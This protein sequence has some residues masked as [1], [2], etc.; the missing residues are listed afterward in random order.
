MT[1]IDLLL[2]KLYRKKLFEFSFGMI[3][4]LL[5]L[6][7]LLIA[8]NYNI[9]LFSIG[10]LFVYYLT[11]IEIV[12]L[13]IHETGIKFIYPTR[14]RKRDFFY[15]YQE[16]KKVVYHGYGGKYSGNFINFHLKRNTE[17][18]EKS[19]KIYASKND[20]IEIMKYIN[21]KHNIES[22]FL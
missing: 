13:E 6:F 1:E 4:I 20:Y 17:N 18:K 15:K 8:T 19:I 21:T 7:T 5:L 9:L 3:V 2:K 10:F 14:L 22:Y 12:K 11:T 16:T